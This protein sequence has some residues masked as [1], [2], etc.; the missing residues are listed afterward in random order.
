LIEAQAYRPAFWRVATEEINYRRFFDINEL[1]A[2]RVEMPEV[3]QAVHQFV[4][5]LLAEKRIT[6][7]RIDH[8]DGLWNPTSY[9][10]RLQANYLLHRFQSDMI[11]SRNMV[12][13]QLLREEIQK[14][15]LAW[16]QDEKTAND[17]CQDHWP[18]YIVA[19]KILA[20]GE[21][22]RDDW[23]VNGTTGYDFLNDVNGLFV[24]CSNDKVFD[25]IYSQFTGIQSDFH[26][27]ANSAKKMIMLVSMAGEINALAHLLDRI[28][29]KNRRYRDFTLNSLTFAIREVIACLPV[30]RTY[31]NEM[32][33]PSQRDQS[34]IEAAVAEARKRNPRTARAI[35]DFIQDT[36]LLRN[37]GHFCEEDRPKLTEFVMRFQQITGPVMAKGVEDT[38][39]YVYNRLVSLN[40]VGGDP[41]RFGISVESFHERNT[42]RQRTWPHSMLASSTHDTKRGEDVRARIN[43]LSET[44]K[45][46]NAVL[47][48]WSRMNAPKKTRVDGEL[49][50]DPNDECLLYQTLLGAWPAHHLSP[51]E[52]ESFKDRVTAYMHKATKEAKVHTSWINPN[53]AYDAAVSNFVRSALADN[54]TNRFLK[55]FQPFQQRVAFYG[56]FDS[57]SQVLLKLTSP[58]IPDTYQG[59]ELWDFSLVDPDNRK[60]V[61]YQY[62]R[63]LLSDLKNRTNDDREDLR[64]LVRELLETSPDGRIKL[65][66]IH[67]TLNFRRIH[68]ALF[69]RA[70][71]VPLK[72]IGEK[73]DHVCAFARSW[74]GE[75]IVITVPRL[76]VRLTGGSEQPPLGAGIWKD[77]HL[78]LPT[79][80]IGQPYRNLFT[81]E[82]ISV[83]VGSGKASLPL[84]VIFQS[85]P[86]ALLEPIS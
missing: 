78:A 86:I 12:A 17:I 2:I 70:N 56:Q 46:W 21:T 72:A 26:N 5:R 7:L 36:L 45:E 71:Y 30:Y 53:E 62:R 63:S 13:D 8:P 38:A 23:A 10:W 80:I 74:E 27:L 25:K 20:E 39:F 14:A 85:F 6:G 55:E 34:Y 31:I 66:V 76:I 16:C 42:Q 35:F 11:M 65:Y 40:E 4:F 50:P 32:N 33:P 68:P 28:S 69:S 3:F 1:A 67:R 52:Y 29:E 75:V 49:A 57:L 82:T 77:T 37:V 18:L 84:S 81:G 58:G 73:Q 61:D 43:V 64:M 24:D 79:E 44:P 54:R 9:F 22:L 83:R 48:R 47:K 15:L 41:S 59:T 19:E 51:E 60:P